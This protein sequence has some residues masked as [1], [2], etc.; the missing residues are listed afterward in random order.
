MRPELVD[1]RGGKKYYWLRT[2]R[3]EVEDYYIQNGPN[4]PMAEFNMQSDTLARFFERNNNDIRLTKLSQ[5]DKW[6]LR[7]AMEGIREVKR[8]ISELEEWRAEVTPII[9][10][11]KAFIK[12]TMGKTKYRIESYAAPDDALRLDDLGG[13]SGK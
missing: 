10:L 5:S 6:V 9:D 11:G 12:A 3:K 1:L 7:V 13:K 4:A 8:R 2:H